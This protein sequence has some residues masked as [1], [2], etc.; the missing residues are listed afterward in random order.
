M[1]VPPD[2]VYIQIPRVSEASE[3]S[4]QVDPA[5]DYP[6]RTV[7]TSLEHSEED[8]MEALDLVDGQAHNTIFICIAL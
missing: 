8:E 2:D 1:D 6:D 5:L 3:P 7:K 4:A